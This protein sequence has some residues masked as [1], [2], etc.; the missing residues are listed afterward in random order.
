MTVRIGFDM[1][2]VLAD[3]AA[4]FRDRGPFGRFFFES[5]HLGHEL[6]ATHADAAPHVCRVNGH[7]VL[8]EGFHPRVRVRIVAVDQRA[9]DIEQHGFQ[10]TA[11]AFAYDSR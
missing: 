4:A 1:D 5:A 3:F 6:V 9:V 8:G 7:A 10:A 11:H 2:G